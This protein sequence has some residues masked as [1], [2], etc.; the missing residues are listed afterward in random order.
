MIAP[1]REFTVQKWQSDWNKQLRNK[2]H[3]IHSN[4]N[5]KINVGGLSRVEQV[6]LTRLRIGHS[7]LTH[8]YLLKGENPPKCQ[9]CNV[10]L[11]VQHIMLDCQRVRESR[12]KY[13]KN[14]SNLKNLFEA[15]AKRDIITFL[16]ETRLFDRL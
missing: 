9:K 7:K 11:S 16:K 14:C 12:K 15:T 8:E 3:S 2:L 4:V 13:L 1:I 6:K 5:G 10:P